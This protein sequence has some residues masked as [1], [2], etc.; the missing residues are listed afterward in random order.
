MKV[1]SKTLFEREIPINTFF[2]HIILENNPLNIT[3][4]KEYRRA[5]HLVTNVSVESVRD[6][7]I[8]MVYLVEQ[9]IQKEMDHKK[10][11]LMFDGWSKRGVHYDALVLSFIQEVLVKKGDLIFIEKIQ[12]LKL[13]ALSSIA[14]ISTERSEEK[15]T[16]GKDDES[17]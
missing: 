10:S 9:H 5:L 11:A 8:K 16:T 2:R 15:T 17:T 6:T 1:Q 14:K 13:V 3:M 12:R 4:S 7:I